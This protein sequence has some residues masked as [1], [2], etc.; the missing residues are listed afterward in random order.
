MYRLEPGKPYFINSVIYRIDDPG[1]EK[2][3]LG[4]S[5]NR[6]FG[7]GM[8]YDAEKMSEERQR[9]TDLAR[10]NGYYNFE[11]AYTTF[12]L[13]SAFNNR[14]VAVFLNIAKFSR[15]FSSNNDSMV[16]VNHTRYT[17][18]NVYVIT[19]PVIGNVR[20]ASFPDTLD[21]GTKGAL[22]LLRKPL[23]YKPALLLDN[24]D[25][26][27]GQVFR[28]DSAQQTYKQLLGLGTFK[29]V[30]I[31]F[32][33]SAAYP[34]R[35]DCYIICVPLIRQSITAETEGTNT[36]GNLGIDGSLNYQNRNSFRGGELVELRL[37]GSIAAQS[38]LR[39]V[40]DEQSVAELP[41]TFN[42][43][44]FGPEFSF[45]VPRAFFP[46]SLLPFRRDMS[47]RT[48][49]RSS[50]N[51]QR[52]P[53]FSRTI[54]SLD[55][56]FNFKTNNNLLRHDFTPAEIYFVR[57]NLTRQF[58]QTLDSLHDAFLVNS[59]QDHVTTLSR[60]TLTY[61]SKENLNTSRRTV[62]YVRWSV[63]SSGSVL[64]KA[65][66]LTGQPRDLHTCAQAQPD[67]LPCG[68][69][70]RQAPREPERAAL[71]AKLLQRRTQQCKGLAGAHA[72]AGGIQPAAGLERDALRQDRRHPA[73]GQR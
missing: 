3:V 56:G 66:E 27:K 65:F 40:E 61:F 1:L 60:Y 34:D 38:Q 14:T 54:T 30:I 43:I 29:T 18:D 49:V 37:Q 23:A 32:L 11:N 68:G 9:I 35:L 36:F 16:Q 64:R 63:Q 6:V 12:D 48:Y 21:P 50:F 24:I 53:D 31:S 47:P 22:F 42:T 72:G 4:D 69:R 20:E 33:Q 51:Y 39:V 58:R 46:F 62:H 59:F 2:L 28:K 44:Q 57:A 15:P 70:H 71:R 13:D 55:Y 17:V 7:K 45:S 73:R 19:E 25:I 5:A 52:R 41:R 26:Y 8:Q 67:R 10:N